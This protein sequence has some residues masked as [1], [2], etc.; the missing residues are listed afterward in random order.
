MRRSRRG[1]SSR[2]SGVPIR[3]GGSRRGGQQRG[4]ERVAAGTHPVSTPW[5]LIPCL[6]LLLLPACLQDCAPGAE[7]E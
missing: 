3:E 5:P 4:T 6:R 1:S 2:R 7:P